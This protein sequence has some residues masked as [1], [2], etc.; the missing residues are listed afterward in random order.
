MP[1]NCDHMEPNER[2]RHQQEASECYVWLCEKLGM[3]PGEKIRKAAANIYGRGGEGA[4][5]KLCE[6]LRSIGEDKYKAILTANLDDD[7]AVTM[8]SWKGEHEVWDRERAE[9]E[10]EENRK[11]IL[12]LEDRLRELDSE[13]E[14]TR[15][16]LRKMG[17]LANKEEK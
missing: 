10:A 1:C 11:M 16:E 6:L 3:E 7:T 13:A 9:R 8:L 17:A 14:D 15:N 4:A 12:E 5:E 2:G